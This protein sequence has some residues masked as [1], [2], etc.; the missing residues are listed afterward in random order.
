[1][2]DRLQF[3]ISTA[4]TAAEAIKGII[5]SAGMILKEGRENFVTEA[6]L[7]SE[8]T[9]ISLI[10]QHFPKENVL[11]EEI[12]SSLTEKDLLSLEH[13]WVIDPIDG[14][15]NFKNERGYSSISIGYVEKGKTQLGVIYNFYRDELFS[16]HVGK[17]AYLNAKPIAVGNLTD[18]TKGVIA[19]DPYYT[20]EGTRHNLKLLLKVNPMPFVIIR[21]C[22]TLSMCEI[23]AGRT[24]L[25]FHTS[26]K[27]WDNAAA[28]LIVKEAGGVVKGL[29]N[30]EVTFLSPSAVVGN[31]QLVEQFTSIIA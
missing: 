31:S 2:E 12:R 15:N 13:L 14:T 30:E 5:P 16:A 11:S 4:K 9:I 3:L 22:G 21:G 10:N 17:G 26:L 28:F 20:S 25:Y 7:I 1:M 6:D 23:A 27:P 19:T 8:K 24:D 18:I 29:Q